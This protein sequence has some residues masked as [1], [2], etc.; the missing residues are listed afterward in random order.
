MRAML[1]LPLPLLVTGVIRADD[2]HVAVALDHAA[3]LTHRLTDGRTFMA[4]LI[5]GG[6]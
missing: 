3:A 1:R 2:Q 4:F 5:G 6:R